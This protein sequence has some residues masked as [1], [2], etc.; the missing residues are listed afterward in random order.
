VLFSMQYL[1]W[2]GARLVRL[3]TNEVHA[4]ARDVAVDANRQPGILRETI[5]GVVRRDG[6]DLS[7]RQLAVM[8]ICYTE[9]GPR[10]VRGLA[11]RLNVSKPSVTRVLD[12]LE[13]LGLSERIVDPSDRRS[14]LVRRTREGA[15]YISLLRTLLVNAETR[16]GEPPPPSRERRRAP[17]GRAGVLA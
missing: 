15:K 8:L 11:A 5:V 9:D 10:T 7:A 17:R 1:R 14:V 13:S 16:P 4:V 2:L 12:R 3:T 6:G